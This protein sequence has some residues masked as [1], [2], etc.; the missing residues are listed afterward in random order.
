MTTSA[1]LLA[2][3]WLRGCAV[4]GALMV[5]IG[6]IAGLPWPLWFGWAYVVLLSVVQVVRPDT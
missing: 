2:D 1:R 5:G 6:A 3:P 4:T